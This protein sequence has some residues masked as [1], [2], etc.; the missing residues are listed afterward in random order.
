M[1]S[2][3]CG[4]CLLD[5]SGEGGLIGH[6]EI[7][8]DLAVHFDPG[9]VQAI[10]KSAIGEAEFTR[11]GVDA[12]DPQGSEIALLGAAVAIGILR[13]LLDGLNGDA[14]DILAAAE[15]AFRRFDDLLV[16]LAGDCTA[17]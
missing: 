3:L 15:I 12:L 1:Q 13:C 5:E 17:F 14:E 10:N 6:G 4:L 9:L 16:G 2:R 7:G 11:R 8:Q